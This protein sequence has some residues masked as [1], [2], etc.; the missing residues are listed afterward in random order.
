MAIGGP[1]R[2]G[3]GAEFSQSGVVLGRHSTGGGEGEEVTYAQLA[4]ALNIPGIDLSA[5]PVLLEG[6]YSDGTVLAALVAALVTLGLITDGT[7][8]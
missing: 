8:P 3:P 7:T 4:A 2:K 5:A 6:D 1:L